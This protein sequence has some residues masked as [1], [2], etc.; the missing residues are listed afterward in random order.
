MNN[1]T[2]K[3]EKLIEEKTDKESIDDLY[4]GRNIYQIIGGL[5]FN[6]YSKDIFKSFDIDVKYS[7]FEELEEMEVED[8]KKVIEESLYEIFS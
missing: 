1:F 8:Q 7:D 3:L 4:R 6:L 2:D 5:T